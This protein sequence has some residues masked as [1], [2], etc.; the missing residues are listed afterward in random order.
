M[1]RLLP[2]AAGHKKMFP[3]ARQ[4]RLLKPLRPS[5]P[6]AKEGLSCEAFSPA[7]L[8]GVF[9]GSYYSERV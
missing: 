5:Y 1:M 2:Q 4:E 7:G 3:K 8:H 9:M 6:C